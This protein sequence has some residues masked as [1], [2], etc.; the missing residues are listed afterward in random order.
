MST[1]QLNSP[2]HRHK[3]TIDKGEL[4]GWSALT[5]PYCY[6][7]SV[8]AITDCRL[9][10]IKGVDLEAYIEENDHFGS[11]FLKRCY[12][13]ITARYWTMLSDLADAKSIISNGL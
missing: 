6:T 9:L 10:R 3:V 8:K 2:D 11:C 12:G 1:I 5:E 13:K 4:I 7:A